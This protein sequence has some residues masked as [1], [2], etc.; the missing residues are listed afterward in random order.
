M[1]DQETFL[2]A[3]LQELHVRGLAP[4]APDVRAFVAGAWP[5]IVEDPDV[6]RWATE[7]ARGSHLAYGGW[8]WLA[9]Y[10]SPSAPE[11]PSRRAWPWV[12]P[13]VPHQRPTP[14]ARRRPPV[15]T[16][17]SATRSIWGCLWGWS[18]TPSPS[19]TGSPS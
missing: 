5:L 18:A 1:P 15:P 4:D 19:P 16:P 10:L 8:P 11:L 7:Y 2:H 17:G 6:P 3:L 9:F 13:G 14:R 12:R